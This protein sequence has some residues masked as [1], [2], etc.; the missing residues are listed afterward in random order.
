M[1]L[2]IVDDHP[3]VSTGVRA[4]LCEEENL[5]VREARSLLEASRAIRKHPPDVMLLDYNL[6]DGSWPELCKIGLRANKAMGI[7]LHATVEAPILALSAFE[8]GAR[9]FLS[10]GG[11]VTAVKEALRAVAAGGV[12]LPKEFAQEL[13]LLRVQCPAGA[14]SLNARETLIPRNSIAGKTDQDTAKALGV[15]LY[16]V[17]RDCQILKA[18]FKAQNMKDVALKA[19]ELKL[20]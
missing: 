11:D 1:N 20:V 18:K 6:P 7:I 16:S 9:G 13:A 3:L 12:W 2:L 8:R 4:L 5:V 17:I 15:S 10:K 19:A 14:Q